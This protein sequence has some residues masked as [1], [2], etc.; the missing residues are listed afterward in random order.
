MNLLTE[1]NKVWSVLSNLEHKFYKF[2]YSLLS[3]FSLKAII[4]RR[5]FCNVT[6]KVYV[7]GSCH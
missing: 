7:N 3:P 4:P 6:V 1:Y 2:H 5:K